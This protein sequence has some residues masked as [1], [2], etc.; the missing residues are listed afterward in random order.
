MKIILIIIV[1]L[2]LVWVMCLC[3]SPAFFGISRLSFLG[4][5]WLGIIVISLV[6]MFVSIR[7]APRIIYQEID[8]IGDD[9]CE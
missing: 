1:N 7:K 9:N 3:F 2:F 5:T 6:W 4:I 8:N